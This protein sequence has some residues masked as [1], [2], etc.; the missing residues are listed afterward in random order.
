MISFKNTTPG[1]LKLFLLAAIFLIFGTIVWIYLR[2]RNHAPAGED[3]PLFSFPKATLSIG[4]IKHTATKDGQ[5]VWTLEAGSGQYVDENKK[6]IIKDL[7]IAFHMNDG[8]TALL[9]ADEGILNSQTHDITINGNIVIENQG[10]RLKTEKIN[11]NH[12][13]RVVYS[14]AP[15]TIENE[16]LYLTADRLELNL[17]ENK[18]YLSGHVKGHLGET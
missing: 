11:Y 14:E 5:T 1:K 9:K 18:A 10:Y 8:T 6:V 16:V 12:D 17:I 2:D 7:A 13:K 15:I 3:K 4:K